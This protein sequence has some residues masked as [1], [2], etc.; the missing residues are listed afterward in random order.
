MF[1]HLLPLPRR[2]RLQKGMA[3]MHIRTA[4][5][6]V[7]LSAWPLAVPAEEAH[8]SDHPTIFHAFRLEADVGANDNGTLISTWDFDGWI[9][10]DFDKLWLKSEGELEDDTTHRAEFWAMYSRNIAEFW[11][12]QV[13]VRY[14]AN[15]QSTA[16]FTGGFDGLAPY[17][18]ETEVHMFVSVDGDVSFRLREETDLLLTQRLIIQPYLEVNLFAQDVPR[19]DVGAGFSTGEFGVQTRYEITREIAPYIDMRYERKF[20]ETASMA[21]A[22][23]EDVDGFIAS[24]GLRLFY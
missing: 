7:F 22:D 2:H 4:L 14:D 21:R 23:G 11:D 8:H 18:L 24:L 16:Y 20:G 3:T 9:G 1:R 5:F 13:G 12:A 15:P 17:F 10:S 6:A 19:Q